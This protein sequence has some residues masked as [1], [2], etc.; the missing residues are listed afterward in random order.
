MNRYDFQRL[1]K[2]RVKEAKVLLD[3]GFFD[4]SYYLL[5]YSV[6]CALKACIA[7]RTRRYDFPPDKRVV[8]AVYDHNLNNLVKAAGLTREH[9]EEVNKNKDFGDNWNVVKGWNS[10]TR[11]QIGKSRFEVRD[12]YVAVTGRKNGV[13]VWL[14]KWW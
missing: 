12:F 7:K 5:G 10:E 1:A 6:E 14:K 8:A 3:R 2:L 4:G 13:F 11:Y 9:E